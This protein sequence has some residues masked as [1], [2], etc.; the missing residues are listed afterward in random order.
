MGALF[1]KSDK[2]K[3]QQDCQSYRAICLKVRNQKGA[4]R[5][6]QLTQ[7]QYPDKTLQWV[8]DKVLSDLDRDRGRV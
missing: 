7:E 5:L 2:Q 1:T 6:I 8:Y 3:E 4:D